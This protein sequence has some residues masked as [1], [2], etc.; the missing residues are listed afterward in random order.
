M[1]PSVLI[2]EDE[3]VLSEAMRDY[4]VRHGYEPTVVGSGEVGL[5]RMRESEMDLVLLDYKLPGM[6]GLETLRH[7]K[8]IAPGAEVVLLTAYG[9]VK[10]AVEAMRA[11]AF[12]YLTKP[13]D[14]EEVVLVLGKA[15]NHARLKRELRYWQ[16][17]GRKGDPRDRIVGDSEATRQL[18]TQVERL[19]TLEREQGGAPSILIT[20]ETGTGKGLVA[21]AIHDLSP[22]ADRP[23]VEVNCAA[24]PATL[25][26]SEIFGYERGAFT[27]AR[28]AKPGL[29]ESA[30]GGTLFFDEIGAMSLE[31]QVKILKVIEEKSVRRLGG[32]R[33][34]VVDV[35]IIAAT[36]SDLEEATRNGGFRPDLLYRLKVLTLALPPLRERPEDILPLAR[37]YLAQAARQYRRPKYLYVDAEAQLLGYPWPGNVR[38]LANVLERI[39][40]LHEGEE[41]RG[42][43]LGLKGVPGRGGTVEV[44]RGGVRVDFSKGGVS[45]AEIERTLIVEA[46]KE[47]GG[48]RRR[49][50]ELLDIS[51]ETLRYRLE[52]H[53]LAPSGAKN[54]R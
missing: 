7:L 11:G 25:L 10:T 45:F 6:D 48:R 26:E 29:F 14:L 33:P 43:D 35:R 52:K 47:A 46:L 40:L 49:A 12:D 1:I 36:N 34:R 2:I 4:L 30:D 21:R 3:K 17:A 5:E 8:Q 13:V 42:D 53:G 19:G 22:R 31:L 18:R 38:E 37:H 27:D 20:G 16:D 41:I 32:L 50:A 23:F 15:W 28:A 44:E 24:I 54:P 51:L 39:V 9:S